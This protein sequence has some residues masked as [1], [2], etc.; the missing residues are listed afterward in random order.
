VIEVA[1]AAERGRRWVGDDVAAKR[2][3]VDRDSSAKRRRRRER[4]R[5]FS[6]LVRAARS[7]RLPFR[8]ERAIDDRVKSIENATF[9][10][11]CDVIGRSKIDHHL[12]PGPAAP[13]T[14]MS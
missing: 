8:V 13:S 3:D 11:L 4:R 14:T 2:F 12:R 6:K 10:L 7:Q 5:D 1:Q 9:A